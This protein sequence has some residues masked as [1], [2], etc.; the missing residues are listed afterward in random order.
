MGRGEGGRVGADLHV[1]L[2]DRGA[3]VDKLVTEVLLGPRG[4]ACDV[5]PHRLVERHVHCH[6][7]GNLL[8]THQ[9]RQQWQ[10][11]QDMHPTAAEQF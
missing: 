9:Q 2:P 3:G 10:H 1:L 6:C 11:A 8:F 7:L 4:A 5:R